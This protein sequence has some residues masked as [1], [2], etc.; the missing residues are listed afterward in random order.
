MGELLD[1]ILDWVDWTTGAIG[2]AFAWFWGFE[3]EN[4]LLYALIT[5]AVI[6]YISGVLSAAV[7]KKLSS[8]IGAKGI[9]KKIIIFALIGITNIIDREFLGG[10]DALR[11]AVI[12][13]YLANEGISILENA[14]II[15][16]PVP[17][18]LKEK[19]TQIK[20]GDE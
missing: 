15:G 2:G 19:L 4:G 5:F 7:Q 20:G 18:I 3:G 13:F 1:W 10:N 14:V 8:E 12:F 17:E 11:T 9:A 16:V 6:D